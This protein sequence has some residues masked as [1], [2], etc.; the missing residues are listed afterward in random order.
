MITL[1]T[2]INC[3]AWATISTEVNEYFGISRIQ[4]TASQMVLMLT[5][6]FTPMLLAP[7]SEAVSLD[8][9][10]NGFSRADEA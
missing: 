1:L 4:F 6:A 7:V 5:I 8:L 2:A 9:M 10:L 3:N